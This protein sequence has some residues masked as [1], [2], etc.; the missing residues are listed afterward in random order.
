MLPIARISNAV[1]GTEE[2]RQARLA[3]FTSSNIW[4]LCGERGLG[5]TG[6]SYIRSRVFEAIS[7]TSSEREFEN[8][9]I[10]HGLINEN[11]G[12][13]ALMDKWQL[14]M[15]VTQKL[16]IGENPIFGGT[17]DALVIKAHG[18][19]GLSYDVCPIEMKCFQAEHHMEMTE[20]ETP[21][22][23]KMADRKLYFQ[24]LDQMELTD[25]LNGFAVFFHP[26]LP[27][28]SGGLH[29]VE[30]RKMYSIEIKGKKEYPVLDDFKLM[31]ERKD[32]AL[33]EFTDRVNKLK[34]PAN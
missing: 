30:V 33:K 28:D 19:D 13:R 4:K 27:R 31:K 11:W 14:E 7:G 8:E 32:L 12:L 6:L 2:W 5:E 24:V 9:S 3:K 10:I 17:P 34:K 25:S 21:L 26:D 1:M 23:L 29:I 16:I 22:H 20:C 18:T 15:L